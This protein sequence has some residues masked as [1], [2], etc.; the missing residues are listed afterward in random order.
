[1]AH[2]NKLESKLSEPLKDFKI[3]NSGRIENFWQSDR[4]QVPQLLYPGQIPHGANLVSSWSVNSSTKP[5]S[6]PKT[7]DEPSNLAQFTSISVLKSQIHILQTQRKLEANIDSKG[8]NE[9]NTLKQV[10]HCLD[11]YK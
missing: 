10:I 3:L 11:W 6:D 7:I 8:H 9:L 5:T 4:G 2:L 1:M